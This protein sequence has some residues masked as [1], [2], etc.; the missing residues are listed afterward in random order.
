[1]RGGRQRLL[2]RRAALFRRFPL[3]ATIARHVAA[4][5]QS[6]DHRLK[7]LV[8]AH[9]SAARLADQPIPRS[10]RAGWIRAAPRRV[11]TAGVASVEDAILRLEV[12]RLTPKVQALMALV[13][14]AFTLLAL[15]GFRL[16]QTRLPVGKGRRRLLAAIEGAKS[17]LPLRKVLGVLRLS[18]GRYHA[19]RGRARE[20]A[21]DDRRSCPKLAPARLAAAEI[22]AMRA[23]VTAKEYAHFSIQ[24]LAL[25][26]QRIGEVFAS[27]STW[28]RLIRARGWRRPR[29]RVHPPKP[30]LGVRAVVPNQLWHVDLTILKLLDGSRAY[31]RAVIDNA[32][33]KILA[34]EVTAELATEA[35]ESVLRYALS[36]V[37]FSWGAV[38]PTAV[39]DSGVENVGPIGRLATQGVLKHVLAQIDVEF[40]NSMIERWFMSLKHQWLY[41]HELPDIETARRLIDRF[42]QEYNSVIPHSALHGRTPNEVYFH[43]RTELPAELEEARA[44]AREARIEANRKAS[45]YACPLGEGASDSQHVDRSNSS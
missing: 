6:Y 11:I 13:R 35:T 9:P 2:G 10:T 28:G 22:A 8:H 27:P 44:A 31:I 3:F 37:P 34:Y 39:S 40:S 33:R 41:L 42:V 19:F 20:C 1:V 23:L 7:E 45:C 12:G 30:K 36:L 32:S 15:S 17:A 29:M 5:R 14:L 26:A 4:Q 21:L 16:E 38:V 24:S 18:E 25:H 43:L